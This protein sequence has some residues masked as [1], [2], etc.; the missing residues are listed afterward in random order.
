M[1]GGHRDESM[2]SPGA[3]NRASGKAP[4]P[5]SA[6]TSRELRKR[7]PCTFPGA[8]P[9]SFAQEEK[10]RFGGAEPRLSRCL[11][12]PGE[13]ALPRPARTYL[14]WRTRNRGRSLSAAVGAVPEV[15]PRLSRKTRTRFATEA[16]YEG[17]VILKSTHGP[18]KFQRVSRHGTMAEE[19]A[20]PA[21]PDAVPSVVLPEA[22]GVFRENASARLSW[23]RG[24]SDK[25][26]RRRSFVR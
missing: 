25:E 8:V 23:N 7:P 13:Q 21:D 20:V 12:K 26:E 18:G 15:C 4:V 16:R 1:H 3:G 14:P 11:C 6:I 17:C 22:R 10:P 2:N 19:G 5:E 24:K 9:A